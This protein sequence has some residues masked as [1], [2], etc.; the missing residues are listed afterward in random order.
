[1]IMQREMAEQPEAVARLIEGFEH[2]VAAVASLVPRTPAAIV[3]VG[4]GSSSNAAVLGRYAI[5]LACGRPTSL[6]APSLLTRYGATP[7]YQ[8]VL[9]VALSQSGATPEVATMARSL[10]ARGARVVAITNDTRSPLAAAAQLVLPLEVGPERAIPATKTVTAQMVQVLAVAAALGPL[11][12]TAQALEPLPAAIATVLGDTA[13]CTTLA[14]RWATTDQ[15]LVV[16]RGLLLCAALET[17]LK[18]RETTG[19]TAVASSSAD[20]QHGPIAA[21][22]PGAPVLLIDGDPATTT[23][24]RELAQRLRDRAAI[25]ARLGLDR[26]DELSLPAGLIPLLLPIVATVRGQQLASAL[27]EARGMDPDQPAGLSKVTPTQ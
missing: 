17:A 16:A 19:I 26:T 21:V 2:N 5:E 22:Q 3:L 24:L 12:L 6:A 4:R 7:D 1:M 14:H 27:A 13:P 9:V 23:D 20:L 18:V 15:L 8:D 11:P 10:R 25:P